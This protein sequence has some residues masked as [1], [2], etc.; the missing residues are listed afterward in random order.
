[1]FPNI[2]FLISGQIAAKLG[3]SSSTR[4]YVTTN[5]PPEATHINL[6]MWLR[7][8]LQQLQGRGT[9]MHSFKTG[10][11]WPESIEKHSIVNYAFLFPLQLYP[12][13]QSKHLK[14]DLII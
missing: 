12:L 14:Y 1:M 4:R 3:I 2:S 6:F 13:C 5:R 9:A 7:V 10:T 8:M 11:C